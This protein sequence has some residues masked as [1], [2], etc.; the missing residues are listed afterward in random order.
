MLQ[1]WEQT[2]KKTQ[3]SNQF[4]QHNQNYIFIQIIAKTE[5]FHELKIQ[6]IYSQV[7]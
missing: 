2:K 5:K 4:S 6:W 3:S 1:Q 7:G